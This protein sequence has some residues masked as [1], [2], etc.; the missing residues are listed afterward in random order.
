MKENLTKKEGHYY[1]KYG[2]WIPK[3]LIEKTMEE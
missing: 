2:N 3:K 1:D